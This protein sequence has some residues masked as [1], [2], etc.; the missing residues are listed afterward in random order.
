MVFKISPI[1]IYFLWSPCLNVD[2]VKVFLQFLY[3]NV[4]ALE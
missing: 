2:T 3:S 4:V 1:D